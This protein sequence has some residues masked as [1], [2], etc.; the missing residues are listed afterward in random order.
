M[1][2][3]SVRSHDSFG[4]YRFNP[5]NTSMI[6]TEKKTEEE[7]NSIKCVGWGAKAKSIT[8]KRH[9]VVIYANA[10]NI[11]LQI[12]NQKWNLKDKQVQLHLS[13]YI[14]FNIFRVYNNGVEQFKCI[15]WAESAKPINLFDPSF[16]NLEEENSD[17]FVYLANNGNDKDWINSL[18]SWEV[19][20]LSGSLEK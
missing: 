3:I 16:D 14:F 8:G 7:I 4:V 1:D 11:Y 2:S 9:I 17:F 20:G 19:H 18:L 10:G 5:L 12:D 15:Y 6:F 13:K